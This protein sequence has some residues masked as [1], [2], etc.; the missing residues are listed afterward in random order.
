MPRHRQGLGAQARIPVLHEAHEKDDGRRAE[1]RP[2]RPLRG[3]AIRRHGRLQD[4]HA[5]PDQVPDDLHGLDDQRVRCV[6]LTAKGPEP[7]AVSIWL[8]LGKPGHDR[9]PAPLLRERRCR[10]EPAPDRTCPMTK[11]SPSST[12]TTPRSKRPR[13]GSFHTRVLELEKAAEADYGPM[14]LRARSR[15]SSRPRSISSR[16]GRN[17]KRASPCSTPR[18][19]PRP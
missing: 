18:T 5:E 9:L 14:R 15:T 7:T 8:A 4:G 2:P 19:R 3:D 17:S 10:R 6:S 11:P 13:P 12:S 16:P 1:G